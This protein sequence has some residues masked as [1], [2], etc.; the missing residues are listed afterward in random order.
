MVLS[1]ARCGTDSVH[2]V[3]L[4]WSERRTSYLGFSLLLFVLFL[5]T[6]LR[7]VPTVGSSVPILAYLNGI[8][9]M[10][11]AREMLLYGYAKV[12]A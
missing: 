1:C 7:Q 11:H 6:Q 10:K 2:V 3:E 12:C 5:S 4:A 9:Y 8:R